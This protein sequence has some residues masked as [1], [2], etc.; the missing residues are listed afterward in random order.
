MLW[1]SFGVRLSFGVCLGTLDAA[2]GRFLGQSI[3]VPLGVSMSREHRVG[4]EVQGWRSHSP[5]LK[6]VNV[7]MVWYQNIRY[8]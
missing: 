2:V 1:R 3:G 8:D 4:L 6:A 5:S 7:S